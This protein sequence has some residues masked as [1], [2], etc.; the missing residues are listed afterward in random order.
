MQDASNPY[1]APG[2]AVTDVAE[3]GSTGFAA[4]GRRVEAGRGTAWIGEGWGFFKSAPLLWIVLLILFFAINLLVQMVPVLGSIASILIGPSL[5]V[6]VYAFAHGLA[7]G[8]GGDINRFFDGFRRELGSL[9]MVGLLYLALVIGIFLVSG[10]ALF[11][12]VGGGL[13]GSLASEPEQAM[14]ALLQGAT[15]AGILIVV[16]LFFGLLVL[17]LAAYW[18]A[19]ALVFFAGMG[20]VAAMQASFGACLRNWL[21]FLVYGVVATLLLIAGALPLMLG[22]L[23]VLPLL[24]ASNYAMFRDIFGQH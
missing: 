6:G 24:F 9:V 19:P 14:A 18:F 16:L 11:M 20:P 23:V 17:T 1:R 12:V 4:P 2:A 8:E 15:G 7:A 21:P 13:I 22:W 5:L 3:A 10:L